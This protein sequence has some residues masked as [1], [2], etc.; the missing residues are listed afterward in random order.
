MDTTEIIEVDRFV[1]EA[2]DKHLYTIIVTQK[3]GVSRSLDGKM[4][5]TPG[6]KSARTS[7]G[8]SV[9]YIDEN[10]Y[11]IVDLNLVVKKVKKA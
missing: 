1:A 2:E 7:E 5:R 11:K 6:I 3:I 10:T 8:Y 9:N 4:F